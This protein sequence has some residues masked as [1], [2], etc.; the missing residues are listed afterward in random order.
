MLVQEARLLARVR[1]G[2]VVGGLGLLRDGDGRLLLAMEHVRGC[3]LAARLAAGALPW[4]EVLALAHSLL[5]ALGAVHEAGLLHNDLAPDNIILREDSAADP[6]LIEFG[7]AT[8][9]DEHADQGA[10]E[11]EFAGKLSWISPERL[12]GS[13]GAADARRPLRVRPPAR[14]RQQRPPPRDGA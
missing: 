4:P 10:I 2:G 5:A 1:H 12:A 13:A 7:L 9:L 6:V 3:T 14:R 11:L 8:A